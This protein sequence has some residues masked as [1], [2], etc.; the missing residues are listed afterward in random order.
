MKTSVNFFYYYYYF[1]PF[2]LI[3]NVFATVLSSSKK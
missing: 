1:I 2:H 3:Y